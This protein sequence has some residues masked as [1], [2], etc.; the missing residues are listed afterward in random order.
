MMNK[1]FEKYRDFVVDMRREFHMNPEL[2]MQEFRT[3]KR[4]MEELE[5]AGISCK[6]CGG[7]GVL[8][9]IKG[10]SSNRMIAM[11]ADMD[12]LGMAE[13]KTVEYRS[14]VEGCMHGCGHDGHTAMLLTSALMLNDLKDKLDG[15]V[16]FLFQPGEETAQGAKAMIED[17][18]LEGVDWVFGTHL[19]NDL[20][21]GKVDCSDGPRMASAASFA[22]DVKGKGGHGSMPNQGVDAIVVGS[23]I[24]MNLQTISS[25][26]TYPLS[27]VVVTVGKFESGYRF[28]ILAGEARLE[29]TTRCFEMDV[30]DELPKQIERIAKNTAAA[31]RAEVDVEY[32]NLVYP[33]INDSEVASAFRSSVAKAIGEE[34]IASVGKTT[35]GE[36]FAYYAAKVPGAFA[37]IGSK[38]KDGRKNFPHHHTKFDFDE[39]ALEVGAKC[40]TQIAFDFLTK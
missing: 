4:V 23:S 38:Y 17:G 8:A 29:G 31:Y 13:E 40:Y 1:A 18:C 24:V 33:T 28:N 7:T 12:A 14:Q 30:F 26:E 20:E 15:T 6:K 32:T 35:G 3:Q 27:P 10:G 2:S 25:R 5:K 9:E 19:W 34:N 22:I 21:V 16:R 11:R 36:D 37:F 39:G